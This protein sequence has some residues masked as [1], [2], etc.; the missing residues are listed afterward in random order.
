MIEIRHE[1]ENIARYARPGHLR[2]IAALAHVAAKRDDLD[3]RAREASQARGY[4]S[5]GT[6]ISTP[7]TVLI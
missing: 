5:D 6:Q 7:Y 1:A 2:F 4:Q 3:L